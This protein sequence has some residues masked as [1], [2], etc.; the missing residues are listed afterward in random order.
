LSA[1]GTIRTEFNV[2]RRVLSELELAVCYR[3]DSG[4][5][6]DEF[7]VPC[8]ERAVLYQRAVGYFTSSGLSAAAK[9]L[10]AFVQTPGKMM[11]VASPHLDEED[12]VAIAKGY[13][14]RHD[15][16]ARALL[17]AFEGNFDQIVKDRLACLAWLIANNRL[18]IKVALPKLGETG[19][20]RGLYHEKIGLFTDEKGN[21]VAFSGSPNE[22]E[23]GLVDNFESIDVFWSWDDPQGRIVV[24]EHHFQRLWSDQTPKLEILPFPEAARQRLLQFRKELLSTCDPESA[25]P[26]TGRLPSR[27][28]SGY[29]IPQEFQLRDYQTEATKVWFDNGCRGIYEMATGTG[30]TITA[31]CSGAELFRRENSLG[32]AILVPFQ[33]LVDQWD[34]AARAFGL[35]PVKCYEST[36][37]WRETL[38][39]HVTDLNIGVRK[40]ICAIATHKTASQPVFLS[41]LGMVRKPILLVCDEVHHL[42]A[43]E[44]SKALIPQAQ[45]RLGLSATPMRWLDPVGNL[46]LEGYFHK[47][48]FTFTLQDAIASGFL[49]HYDYYPHLVPL[50]DDEFD[51]YED[52]S[53]QIAKVWNRIDDDD[54]IQSRLDFLL[55]ERADVLNCARGKLGA[56]RSLLP[57]PQRVQFSLFYCAP[58]QIDDVVRLLAQDLH[59]RVRRFT[60]EENADER[61]VLLTEFEEGKQQALIAMKCL[62]EGVDVPATKTAYILASSS[63]PR[64]F[65]Q[66]RGRILR[67]HPSKNRAIIHDLI[68]VPPIRDAG[69]EINEIERRILRRELGRFKEFASAADN[70]YGATAAI[71]EVARAF[72][73][74]D[75]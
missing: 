40:I 57:E 42:G 68:A 47:S 34:D 55:R 48:V 43:P 6:V 52:I 65:I 29:E 15:V 53:R 72:G 1:A 17:R 30:K 74:L 73:I 18:E 58:G 35:L 33:H 5:I 25:N 66:R 37:S 70:E 69:T 60:A 4:N 14:A 49:C 3:S 31:L 24:K 46:I 36:A 54:R 75:F 9:G 61:T 19:R 8:L 50:A 16:V 59:M 41:I 11:L 51:R 21:K 71:L 62:D 38:A 12:C 22:T 63:N 44:Y 10:A 13:E 20:R 56:L 28:P 7:Y 27:P 45:F 67:T 23:G 32:L 64:E 2:P 26:R 39:D